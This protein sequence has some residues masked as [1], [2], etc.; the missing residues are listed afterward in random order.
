MGSPLPLAAD[1]EFLFVEGVL[2]LQFGLVG[3]QLQ[4]EAQIRTNL[5]SF[6]FDKFESL[7][8]T[9]G[10]VLDEVGDDDSGR[11][12]LEVITLEIPAPQ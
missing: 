2:E 10:S 8:E 3:L 7:W 9:H 1:D 4:F 12:D 11:L 6:G 5:R